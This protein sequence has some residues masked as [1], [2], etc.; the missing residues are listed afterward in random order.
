MTKRKKTE[1]NW[2][3]NQIKK[4][5]LYIIFMRNT[6]RFFHGVIPLQ[7][8]T[9]AVIQY[10]RKRSCSL[11]L[12]VIPNEVRNPVKFIYALQDFTGL[13][14]TPSEASAQK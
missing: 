5:P 11:T 9:A 3:K 8:M 12:H 10:E 2:E 13:T 14:A 4:F 6:R 1:T 7:G